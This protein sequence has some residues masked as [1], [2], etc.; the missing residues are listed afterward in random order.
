MTRVFKLFLLFLL[1][2][3]G[4]WF[5]AAI[6]GRWGISVNLMLIFAIASCTVLP[7]A[8]GYPVAFVS[9]LFLDFFSTKLFGANAFTFTCCSC[10]VYGL[11]R[12]LDFDGFIPQMAVVFLGSVFAAFLNSWL[13]W[14]FASSILWAGILNIL[15]G[16]VI[17]AISAPF[18][19]KVIHKILRDGAEA[20]PQ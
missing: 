19:F 2:T 9:G 6:L 5:F 20:G 16:A 12:R 11:A 3:I 14:I 8:W 13:I 1:A 15:S 10:A 17:G 7:R 4:H 18:V